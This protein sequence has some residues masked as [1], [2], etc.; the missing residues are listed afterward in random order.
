MKNIK[1]NYLL[2]MIFIEVVVLTTFGFSYAYFSLEIEGNSKNIVMQTGDLKLE[3]I[4][5]T[6]LN[7]ENAVPGD[8]ITKNIVIKNVGTKDAAYNLYW[9]NLVNTIENF[10]L[11]LTL[12]CKKYRNYGQDNQEEVGSCEQ[13]Y[14]AIPYS[15]NKKTSNIKKNINIEEGITHEYM[16]KVEF[17]NK[18]YSQ[19]SNLNKKFSGV[20]ELIE[21]SSSD[22]EILNCSYDG[23]LVVGSEYI[24]GSYTYKYKQQATN[25]SWE[26]IEIDGWGVQLTDRTSTN[27]VTDNVCTT[28]NDK[29][30]VSTSYMYYNSAAT[31]INL[32]NFDTSKVTNMA[33]MFYGSKATELDVSNFN[34]EN[35]NN[36]SYMFATSKAT[37][38]NVS[39]FKTNKVTNMS[40]MFWGSAT[41]SLD[42]SNFNTSNVTDMK[43]MFS[44]S[45]VTSL[46]V[47]KFDTSNVINMA[48]MFQSCHAKI[49]DVSNFNTSNVTTMGYMFSSTQLTSLD[50]SNFDTRKVTNMAYMFSTSKIPILDLSSFD[51]S[52]VTTM[53]YMFNENTNLKTIYVSNKFTTKNVTVSINMFFNNKSL[54]GNYGTVYDSSKIDKTY[55]RIDTSTTPGYFTLKAT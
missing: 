15:F 33:G 48:N 30:V 28:I 4:D 31:S 9:N 29:N 1:I 8:Y 44:G 17:D 6:E 26:N 47:S 22:Y 45:K 18:S 55:A 19:D 23:E 7:L 54:V 38:L 27:A 2:F 25:N 43:Y 16:V 40:Y 13:I 42:V 5:G 35:V 46:D 21:K 50:L 49:L 10:E 12:E 32:N 37:S 41:D 34:T 3:Y 36:M 14:Q 11:H 52:N 39:N 20:I 51:T 53:G 24:N